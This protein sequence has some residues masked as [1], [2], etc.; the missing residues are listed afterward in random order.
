MKQEQV[1]KIICFGTY[2]VVRF[3]DDDGVYNYR[4][5]YTGAGR[6][7]VLRWFCTLADALAYVK[8]IVADKCI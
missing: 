8:S 3:T 7:R 4:V 6:T 2:K 5:T 1:A